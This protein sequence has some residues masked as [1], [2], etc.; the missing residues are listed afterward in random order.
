[1]RIIFAGTTPNAAEILE[2]LV[3]QGRHQVV[4][5]ISREDAPVGRKRVLTASPVSQFAAENQLL[6][7]KTNKIDDEVL[8]QLAAL[9]ADLGFVV[10]YGSL[11]KTEV[12]EATKFG[13]VNVHFS[14][15]PAW[16]GAAPVQRALIAGDKETGITIF[17]LE[18]GMDTGPIYSQVAT[19]IEPDENAGQL[20]DRLTK[21][22]ITTLDE[23]LA[24]I[25]HQTRK[26]IEQSGAATIARKLQRAEAQIDWSR[27]SLEIENLVRGMNPEP[28]AYTTV[29]N[30]IF[31]VLS[32]RAHADLEKMMGSANGAVGQENGRI[33]VKCGR[34]VLELLL[35]QPESKKV[36]K[37]ADWFRGT[38]SQVILG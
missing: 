14:L 31:R 22:T 20:L 16:R 18:A 10:A 30:S 17:Q 23:T 11:L 26:P 37:A 38:S 33:F 25:E 3:G 2:Y 1:L 5:V 6:L 15:L 7:I 24:A 19:T 35:V 29:G 4:A 8:T 28:V 21:L 32:A 12:L 36:M 9:N 27:S 13:W 34:G